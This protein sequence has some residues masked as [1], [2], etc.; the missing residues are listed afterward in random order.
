MEEDA[1][2]NVELHLIMTFP[3]CTS[4]T[5]INA[6]HFLKAIYW[7]S[8]VVCEIRT[9]QYDTLSLD[10]VSQ[11]DVCQNPSID[12]TLDS[13]FFRT[14]GG[15]PGRGTSCKGTERSFM[16]HHGHDTHR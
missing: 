11:C 9:Q 5:C 3:E 1:V 7:R 4:I 15:M 13:Y 8:G 16:N 2:I 14:Y 12:E 10:R 6:E